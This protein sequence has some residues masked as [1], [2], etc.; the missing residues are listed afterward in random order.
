MNTASPP[1]AVQPRDWSLLP[2][3]LPTV[4][5]R[6]Q[7]IHWASDAQALKAPRTVQEGRDSLGLPFALGDH[8]LILAGKDGI[9]RIGRVLKISL[10]SVA[11]DPYDHAPLRSYLDLALSPGGELV[12][13]EWGVEGSAGW[14]YRVF[15]QDSPMPGLG[16]YEPSFKWL[17]PNGCEGYTLLQV[18]GSKVRL[19]FSD[20]TFSTVLDRK[21]IPLELPQGRAMEAQLAALQLDPLP[22]WTRI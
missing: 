15:D 13:L 22:G 11:L 1:L 2:E 4:R 3:P 10:D 5:D 21:L 17:P 8:R 6:L 7:R 19:E 18:Q 16:F 14:G 20:G 12:E 9:P